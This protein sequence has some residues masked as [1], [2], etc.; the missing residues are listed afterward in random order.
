MRS[1]DN[2]KQRKKDESALGNFGDTTPRNSF[3]GGET[4][5][6]FL[7]QKGGQFHD[8]D[9]ISGLAHPGDGRTLSTFDYD[10][11]GW[12][13]FVVASAN[14]PTVQL[15]RNR[16]GDL[17]HR[18]ALGGR[19]VAL[20]FQ[21]GNRG[22][23]AAAD[24]SP[25]DGYGAL[26]VLHFDDQPLVREFRCGDGRATQNSETMLVGVGDVDVV[27]KI[28]VRWPSGR[29]QMIESVDVGSLV[30]FFEN[31]DHG[32]DGAPFKVEPY[33]DRRASV[34]VA[35]TSRDLGRMKL[36][37]PGGES[38]SR[39]NVLVA[40]STHCKTCKKVQP[41]LASLRQQFAEEDVRFFGIGTDI[42]E[43]PE[44]LAAYVTEHQPRY[45]VLTDLSLD[46]RTRMR[47]FVR[48]VYKDDLSP[49]SVITDTGGRILATMA[50]IPTA[51]KLREVLHSLAQN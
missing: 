22:S 34:P 43:T 38:L 23:K 8:L 24:F 11:D 42:D 7:S 3:S 14:A 15:Y 27:E 44:Q 19:V 21:G 10:R 2:I 33:L 37:L 6:L 51:S 12:V 28:E 29:T 17:Y 1:D 4:D 45:Q 30:T 36:D 13:D 39:L 9:A 16:I 18:D 47:D 5:H 20:R 31:P 48:D 26:A 49:V 35:S 50:G 40:M 46:E 41:Y 32:P 25:R